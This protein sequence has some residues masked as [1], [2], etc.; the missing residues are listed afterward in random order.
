MLTA[1]DHLAIHRLIALYGHLTDER[2]FS[3]LDEVFTSDAAYDLAYRDGPVYYGYSGVREL[4]E[5]LIEQHALAHHTGT[6][7]ID[8]RDD[9]TADVLS[10]G[11]LVHDDGTVHSTTYRQV[12][13]RTAKGWRLSYLAPELRSRDM[14]PPVS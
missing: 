4:F 5:E 12:A 3:R 8:E 6:V 14:I 7:V 11:I 9:D 1:D 13:V 2:Q 10:K